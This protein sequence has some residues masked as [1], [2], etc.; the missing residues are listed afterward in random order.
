M[1]SYTSH[2]YFPQAY[3]FPAHPFE[4]LAATNWSNKTIMVT[5]PVDHT[6]FQLLIPDCTTYSIPEHPFEGLS[7]SEGHSLAVTSSSRSPPQPLSQFA[8]APTHKIHRRITHHHYILSNHFLSQDRSHQ[9]ALLQQCLQSDWLN[10]DDPEPK[11]AQSHS[12]FLGFLAQNTAEAAFK[13]EFDRC[14]KTFSRQDRALGHIR[15]HLGH[16]PYACNL[17]C[18]SATCRERFSCRSYLQSHLTRPKEPCERW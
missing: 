8:D 5:Q 12:I 18:S 11:D 6:L 15:R 2:Y 13:C 17:R 4:P 7:G 16:R 3:T 10:Q 1:V 9:R 14:T